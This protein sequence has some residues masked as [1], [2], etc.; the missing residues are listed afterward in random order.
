MPLAAMS[1]SA[2]SHPR[3]TAVFSWPSSGAAPAR[4]MSATSGVVSR[5]SGLS[6]MRSLIRT[7]HASRGRYPAADQARDTAAGI[8]GVGKRWM[9]DA[10]RGTFT[11]P[12]TRT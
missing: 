7:D 9:A 4:V 6:T 12:R 2:A 1:R 5:S 8:I 3:D 11:R 10:S